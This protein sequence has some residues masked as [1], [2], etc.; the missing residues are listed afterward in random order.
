M[1]QNGGLAGT[2]EVGVSLIRDTWGRGG[3]GGRSP[4][5]QEHL[6]RGRETRD[7]EEEPSFKKNRF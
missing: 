7:T 1:V 3:D 6:R 2:Q 5:E 4:N